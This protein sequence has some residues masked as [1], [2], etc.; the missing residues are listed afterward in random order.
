MGSL[1]FAAWGRGVLRR[2]RA[3]KKEE[4]DAHAG[5]IK[6]L[7][8]INDDLWSRLDKKQDMIDR[9]NSEL[10]TVRYEAMKLGLALGR[11]FSKNG[12]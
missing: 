7:R 5:L 1:A 4:Y 8:A 11:D 12:E 3:T 10:L 2:W 6:E 9:L